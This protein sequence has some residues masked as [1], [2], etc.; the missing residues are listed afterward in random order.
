MAVLW[1]YYGRTMAR[2]TPIQVRVGEPIE[3]SELAP[4]VQVPASL[5]LTLARTLTLTL[6]LTLTEGAGARLPN[7]NPS[8]NPN[9]NPYRGCRCPPP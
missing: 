2:C 3:I 4:R 7:L 8:P 9:P 6:T 5:T 1:P